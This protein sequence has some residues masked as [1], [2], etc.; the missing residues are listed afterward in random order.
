MEASPDE[1][2]SL[3]ENSCCLPA[4]ISQADCDLWIPTCIGELRKQLIEL[5]DEIQHQCANLAVRFDGLVEG[6]RELADRVTSERNERLVAVADTR[7]SL[8]EECAVAISKLERMVQATAEGSV[9]KTDHQWLQVSSNMVSLSETCG[10]L[11]AEISRVASRTMAGVEEEGF[12]EETL[13]LPEAA[14]R[15]RLIE[16]EVPLLAKAIMSTAQD[17]QSRLS[18]ERSVRRAAEAVLDARIKHIEH[19]VVSCRRRQ[20]FAS[21]LDT[22]QSPAMLPC[23]PAARRR[24][25]AFSSPANSPVKRLSISP[26]VADLSAVSNDS[27]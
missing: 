2:E 24:A 22:P 15:L 10:H 5:Q 20:S 9:R 12:Q 3:P 16:Q 11:S 8:Q 23:T 18:E 1:E 14:A 6:V 13:C 27:P 19:Q 21:P 26:R 4:C 17:V 7:S 25:S